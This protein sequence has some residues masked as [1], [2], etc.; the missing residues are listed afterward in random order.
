MKNFIDPKLFWLALPM[1]FLAG[2][3]AGKVINHWVLKLTDYLYEKT[4]KEAYINVERT[5]KNWLIPFSAQR[6]EVKKRI[7]NLPAF[8]THQKWIEFFTGLLFASYFLF[9]FYLNCQHVPEVAPDEFWHSGRFIFHLVLISLLIAATATDFRDY[10]IP[11][12]IIIPGVIFAVIL[13][14]F[15]GQLQIIHIWVDW[16]E[17]IPGFR[18]PF[19]PAWLDP[20]RHLHGLS[21]SLAGLLIGGGMTWFARISSHFILGRE[22]LGFGDV[23][24]MAMIGSFLGWQP[25]VFVFVFAPIVG[26]F[27]GV[28]IRLMTGR[29][30]LALGPYLC[31]SAMIVLFSWKWLWAKTKTT[32]GDPVSIAIL[33]GTA[34]GAYLFLLFLLKMYHA[35]PGKPA[36]EEPDFL[37]DE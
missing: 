9:Y 15:S 22:S 16:N 25:T 8:D 2:I 18:G 6:M 10:V 31:A 4:P 28:I 37:S 24:L 21:W 17:E 20:H 36:P 34:L 32:F 12:Q 14:T 19:I 29:S 27:S 3:Y 33:L 5:W 7:V 11:D 35:I 23:T 30:F 1:L 26:I 13:A